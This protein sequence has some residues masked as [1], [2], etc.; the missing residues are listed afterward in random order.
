MYFLSIT[1]VYVWLQYGLRRL[2]QHS[3]GELWTIENTFIVSINMPH[4]LY[5]KSEATFT[6][7]EVH[8]CKRKKA[9]EN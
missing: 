2:V 7:H 5:N 8:I 6:W 9:V 1:D 4:I 3:G